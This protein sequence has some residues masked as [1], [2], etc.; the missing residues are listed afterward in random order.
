[1]KFF[2]IGFG[3]GYNKQTLEQMSQSVNT[4][5]SGKVGNQSFQYVSDA[6]NGE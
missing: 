5:D 6:L 4:G 2:A 3:T 1:M